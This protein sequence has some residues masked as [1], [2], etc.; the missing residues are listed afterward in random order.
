MVLRRRENFHSATGDQRHHANFFT[1]E[2]F[3]DDNLPASVAKRAF[4]HDVNDGL[5]GFGD[6]LRDDD[7]FTGS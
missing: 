7:T 3:L 4:F 1:G 6:R 2:T 5:V